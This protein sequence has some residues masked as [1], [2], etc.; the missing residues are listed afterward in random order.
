MDKTYGENMN[1][2]QREKILEEKIKEAKD[3]YKNMPESERALYND[4]YVKLVTSKVGTKI[5]CPTF[6]M[7]LVKCHKV[8]KF[9][10]AG[11]H[12]K[13][14]EQMGKIGNLVLKE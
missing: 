11:K 13:L 8:F 7:Y 2:E 6:D 12:K 1:K 5:V 10:T 14:M 3:W 4:G 9:M